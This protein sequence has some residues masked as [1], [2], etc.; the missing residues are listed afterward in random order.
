MF[1]VAVEVGDADE[2]A[3]GERPEFKARVPAV[4][5]LRHQSRVAVR[6]VQL[7]EGRRLEAL[8]D[9]R[10]QHHVVTERPGQRTLRGRVRAERIV[11]VVAG[12]C[13]QRQ[14]VVGRRGLRVGA[15]RDG[16]GAH[17]ARTDVVGRRVGRHGG[18]LVLGAEDEPRPLA[19]GPGA[20]VFQAAVAAG[21]VE[22]LG[23]AGKIRVVGAPVA[24]GV[25]QREAVP[26]GAT[27]GAAVEAGVARR[28]PVRAVLA[29]VAERVGRWHQ[30]VVFGPRL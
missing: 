21:A 28:L 3:P 19:D 27:E 8:A 26:E 5:G 20:L 1:A 13:R 18:P 29:I 2:A 25:L 24:V 15:A 22:G 6:R 23:D 30:A 4:G 11:V 14:A 17:Q 9:A 12:A 7:V 16:A 10:A